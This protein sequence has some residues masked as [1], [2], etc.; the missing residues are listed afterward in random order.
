MATVPLPDA[1]QSNDGDADRLINR[2]VDD[3]GRIQIPVDPIQRILLEEYRIEVP[4]LRY[5][6]R[7]HVRVSA[8]VYNEPQD[9][10]RLAE[11]IEKIQRRR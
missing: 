9:Y 1:L 6:G 3:R 8:H 11:A 10:E 5:R 7:L 2:D 4:V